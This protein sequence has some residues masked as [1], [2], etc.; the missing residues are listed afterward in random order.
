MTNSLT[1][2]RRVSI[3]NAVIQQRSHPASPCGCPANQSSPSRVLTWIVVAPLT[4]TIRSVPTEILLGP[5]EGLDSA[6]V[7]TFDNLQPIRT[8]YLTERIGSVGWRGTEIC[9]ALAALTDC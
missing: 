3:N 6:C 2:Q 9:D 5:D 8:S 7:A 4:R 1:Q